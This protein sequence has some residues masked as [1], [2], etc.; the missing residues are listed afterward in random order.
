MERNKTQTPPFLS[1][2]KYAN[3]PMFNHFISIFLL[4]KYDFQT[5]VKLLIEIYLIL[6]DSTEISRAYMCKNA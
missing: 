5:S 4:N 1:V 6:P 2:T 3:D